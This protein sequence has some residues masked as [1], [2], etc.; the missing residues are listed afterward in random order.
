MFV[1]E[2]KNFYTVFVAR[3]LVHMWIMKLSGRFDFLC[4]FPGDEKFHSNSFSFSNKLNVLQRRVV[5]LSVISNEK[6][7]YQ[8]MFDFCFSIRNECIF[9]DDI[10]INIIYLSLKLNYPR[11]G[12]RYAVD[13]STFVMSFH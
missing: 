9:D 7:V 3:H 8:L 10:S 6:R 2:L 5:N 12:G 4:S 1:V 13:V 11:L